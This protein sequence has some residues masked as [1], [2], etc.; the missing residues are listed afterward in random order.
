MAPRDLGLG[1]E[2][3]VLV[4]AGHSKLTAA[5][6]ALLERI[7]PCEEAEAVGPDAPREEREGG[8]R[9]MAA[10]STVGRWENRRFGRVCLLLGLSTHF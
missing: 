9:A 5:S 4:F 7:E 10:Q 3:P 6:A 1:G 8:A 2:A